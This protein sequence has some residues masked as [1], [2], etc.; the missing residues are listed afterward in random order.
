MTLDF[1]YD[2]CALDFLSL[3][4]YLSLIG[5]FITIID[6]IPRYFY[7]NCCMPWCIFHTYVTTPINDFLSSGLSELVWNFSW[8]V[9]FGL[10]SLY[11]GILAFL[12]LEWYL[13]LIFMSGTT[14]TWYWCHNYCCYY[15]H[16]FKI[17]RSL[18]EKRQ[19]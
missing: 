8:G 19:H 10:K 1:Y 16:Y 5:N 3:T 18:P 13:L 6:Y 15:C 4:F 14:Y 11:F 7:A 9:I 17:G 12:C 2:S